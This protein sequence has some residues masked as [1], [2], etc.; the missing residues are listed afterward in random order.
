[1]DPAK[2]KGEWEDIE[3]VWLT[4]AEL[5]RLEQAMLPTNLVQ[6]RDAFL[7]CC[8]TGLRLRWSS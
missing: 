8:Y 5:A 4:A 2:L 6:V 3:K 1:M 7:F